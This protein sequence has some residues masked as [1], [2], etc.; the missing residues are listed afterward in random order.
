MFECLTAK[1]AALFYSF[2]LFI[3]GQLKTKFWRQIEK[4]E[5]VF[6]P[7]SINQI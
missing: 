3:F 1:K 5:T 2:F 4:K 6:E 7:K